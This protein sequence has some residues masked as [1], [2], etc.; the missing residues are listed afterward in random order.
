MRKHTLR[1]AIRLALLGA[2]FLSAAALA[3]DV[4][5]FEPNQPIGY[6][7][8][9]T[10]S[11]GTITVHGVIGTLFGLAVPDVDFYSFY[12]EPSIDPTKTINI[13]TYGFMSGTN[14]N[15]VNTFLA[16]FGPAPDYKVL[17]Y[18]ADV[19]LP[20]GL[21]HDYRDAVIKNFQPQVAGMYTV[22]VTGYPCT[23]IDG[24]VLL[25]QRGA[26]TCSPNNTYSNGRYTLVISGVGSSLMQINIEI[27]PGGGT[28]TA[29]INPKSKGKIPVALLS[30]TDFNAVMVNVDSLRFGPNG[31]E[32]KASSCGNDGEDVN[33]DGLLD[34]VCHFDNQS[35]GFSSTDAEGIV[36]GE[37]S[38]SV[39]SSS[40]TSTQGRRFEG[41]GFLKVM[42]VQHAY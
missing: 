31:T 38:A 30:S 33:G 37:A 26:P 15:P 24:G 11:D 19:G 28:S 4:D 27:K 23:L 17:R 25:G 8:S 35:A 16:V 10:S 36:T 29:P 22:G 41:R 2:S 34:L 21:G 20:P 14:P 18:S 40:E 1:N 3:V 13:E 7:Q 12:A 42:P 39:T 6:P 9:L 32:A 5:E